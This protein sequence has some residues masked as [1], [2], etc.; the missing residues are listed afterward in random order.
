[1]PSFSALQIELEVGQCI[2]VQS[3]DP[4]ESLLLVVYIKAACP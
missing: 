3:K 4:F 2:M 1:M